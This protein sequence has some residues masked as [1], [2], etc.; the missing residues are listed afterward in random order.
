MGYVQKITGRSAC[1]YSDHDGNF[2]SGQCICCAGWYGS[3]T[4]RGGCDREQWSHGKWRSGRS[5]R[6]WDKIRRCRNRRDRNKGEW[7]RT[8]RDGKWYDRDRGGNC[9]SWSIRNRRADRGVTGDR[10]NGYQGYLRIDG[11]RNRQFRIN[12]CTG[13]FW[14]CSRAGWK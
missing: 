3:C 7:N 14:C 11:Q 13:I 2:I 10:E 1:C 4:G 8:V 12:V 5:G 6:N 9:R